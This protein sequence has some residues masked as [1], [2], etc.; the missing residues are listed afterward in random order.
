MKALKLILVLVAMMLAAAACDDSSDDAENEGEDEGQ[1]EGEDE[2]EGDT[3][4]GDEDGEGEGEAEE[5]G[6]GE[7][8]II[9]EFTFDEDDEGFQTDDAEAN[10][11]G[12]WTHNAE[13]GTLDLEFSYEG[14]GEEGYGEKTMVQRILNGVDWSEAKEIEYTIRVNDAETGGFQPFIKTGSEWEWYA[15]WKNLPP[16]NE[17]YEYSINLML[18]DGTE[19]PNG[20]TIDISQI[21]AVGLEVSSGS[22]ATEPG[23]ISISLDRIVVK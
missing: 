12:V 6:E 19:G 5:E 11:N 22:E 17:Y 21:M 4:T 23:T 1:A 20:T 18:A 8:E 3:G 2:G 15:E 13:E 7:A 14:A 16:D 10:P 9:F